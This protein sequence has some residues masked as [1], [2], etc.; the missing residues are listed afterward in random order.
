[1]S[2]TVPIAVLVFLALPAFCGDPNPRYL[3]AQSIA[4]Y[5]KDWRAALDFTYMERDVSG[6]SAGRPKTAEL[7]Q[8]TVVDGTP[9]SRLIAKDGHPLDPEEARKEEEKYRKTI[10][11]RDHETPA[12][13]ERRIRKYQE[14]R[15]FLIEIPDAFNMKLLGQETLD[16]RT[17]WVIALTPKEGYVPQSRNARI[18]PN[19][20]GKLW[21]DEQDL[22]W[23]KA[24]ATV[25]GAISFGW[26]LARISPGASIT[27]KQVRVDAGHWMPKEIDV[28]GTA[29]I[30]LVKNRTVNQTISYEDY[31]RL[32]PEPAPAAAKNR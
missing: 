29:R 1:M 26:I 3:V 32:R 7:S 30:L 13:R 12:Q 18:F 4:N 20:E 11:E 15:Q 9:W 28:K 27:M 6:D 10:E 22:R 2:T 25:T 8:V 19:I 16:G 24:V 17:N 5:E 31:R 21:I 23:T 14:E